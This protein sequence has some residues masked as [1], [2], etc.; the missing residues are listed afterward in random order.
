M[1]AEPA[2]QLLVGRVVD[3]ADLVGG[4]APSYELTIDLGP[5]GIRQASIQAGSNYAD[6]D[7]LVGTQVVCVEG[8]SITVL[9][10]H[11]HSKGL[12]LLRPDQDVEDGTIAA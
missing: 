5:R 12:V 3:A 1:S 6:R 4:R 7:R 9:F 2:P 8:D 10:A 11:S